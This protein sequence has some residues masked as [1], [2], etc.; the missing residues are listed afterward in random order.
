[1]VKSMVAKAEMESVK[2]VGECS[3]LVR[4]RDG[5]TDILMPGGSAG[6]NLGQS[7]W[8]QIITTTTGQTLTFFFFFLDVVV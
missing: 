6:I 5:E 4:H 7:V 2:V 1:M 3:V 8:L